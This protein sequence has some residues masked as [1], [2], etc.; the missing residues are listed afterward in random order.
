MPK[1]IHFREKCIG[2]NSCVEHACDY[3]KMDADGKSTLKRGTYK[4]GIGIQEI[5][6]VEIENNLAASRDC[7]VG[8][9][10]LH[11]DDGEK[12]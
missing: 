10:R 12:L 4:K 11:T 6:D 3:W 9:I 1:I 8:I 7:P 5:S 2:C